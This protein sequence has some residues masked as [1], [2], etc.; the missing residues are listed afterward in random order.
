MSANPPSASPAETRQLILQA[1]G[2]VFAEAGFRNATVRAICQRAGANI[3]AVNYHFGDKERLYIAVLRFA[4]EY[5]HGKYPSDLGLKPGAAPA[6]RLRAFIRSF[7][8]RLFDQGPVA[9]HANL[10]ARE[11]V[12]PTS[13]LDLVVAEKIRPQAVQ[14]REIVT[15]L[16]GR[17]ATPQVVRLCACSVVS[18]CLFYLHCRSVIQRLFPEQAYDARDL[19]VLADHITRFSMAALKEL[20][21]RKAKA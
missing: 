7:L 20:A 21:R 12:E 2:E 14:L 11:M 6:A 13:A 1:A 17:S 8:F 9:W 5:A 3:A 4:Q 16:L 19:E 18:Q 10:M 15:A